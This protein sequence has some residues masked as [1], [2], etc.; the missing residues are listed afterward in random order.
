MSNA[1]EN[2]G[3]LFSNECMDILKI[4]NTYFEVRVVGG[5]VRDHLIEKYFSLKFPRR[6]DYD[7]VVKAD[8]L[9]IIKILKAHN[10]SYFDDS[11][12]YG[13]LKIHYKNVMYD[14]AAPRKDLECFGRAA[15]VVSGSYISWL[16]DSMRRDFSINAIYCDIENV[17]YDYHSGIKDLKEQK[18]K[19]VGD[20]VSRIRE[21]YLRILRFFRFSG[22][23][24]APKFDDSEVKVLGEHRSMLQNLSKERI[25]KEM[26]ALLKTPYCMQSLKVMKSCEILEIISPVLNQFIEK[27]RGCVPYDSILNVACIL[28]QDGD[29]DTT[30]I[31][32]SVIQLSKEIM[33]TNRE[34]LRLKTLMKLYEYIGR[35]D[36]V[37]DDEECG[38]RAV[39]LFGVQAYVDFIK[40]CNVIMDRGFSPSIEKIEE[41]AKITLPINGH[42]IRPLVRSNADIG[43]YKRKATQIYIDSNFTATKEEI[44][45]RLSLL[46][47]K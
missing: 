13:V 22:L 34:F 7:I 39:F 41:Y 4:L 5:S 27:S 14:I 35:L 12:K 16:E 18:I 32:E 42:D 29:C 25:R 47:N 30:T 23:F 15:R 8:F 17:M 43:K 38:K 26:M 44:I 24:H 36:V 9:E 2:Q 6:I 19:F 11:A 40:I 21:D 46:N 1:L 28:I 3:D 37:V 20:A 31:L 10:L 33:F 45:M